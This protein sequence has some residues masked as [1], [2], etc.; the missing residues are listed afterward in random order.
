MKKEILKPQTIHA[1]LMSCEKIIV[2]RY[3]WYTYA[4]TEHCP[5]PRP[6]PISEGTVPSQS[7]ASVTIIVPPPRKE[8]AE[9]FR[10]ASLPRRA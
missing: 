1:T 8:R 7:R 10:G 9:I 5:E 2:T 6:N 4:P 3:H